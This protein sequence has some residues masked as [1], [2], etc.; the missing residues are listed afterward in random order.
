MI[1]EVHRSD[2]IKYIF[3]C[4]TVAL[5]YDQNHSKKSKIMNSLE[6]MLKTLLISILTEKT[7]KENILK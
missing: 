5:K 2:I 3:F 6:D 4:P 7:K 1:Y